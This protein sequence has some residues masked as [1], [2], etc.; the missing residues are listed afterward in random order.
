MKKILN[1]LTDDTMNEQ[2]FLI[3]FRVFKDN[4]FFIDEVKKIYENKLKKSTICNK[5]ILINRNKNV[6]MKKGLNDKNETSEKKVEENIK[7]RKCQNEV[8]EYSKKD[9][10]LNVHNV[11]ELER[12]K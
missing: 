8:K 5:A 7:N 2:F 6:E 1:A 10:R 11:K 3:I 9:T 12:N 4:S